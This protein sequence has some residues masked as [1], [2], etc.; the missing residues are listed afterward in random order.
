MFPI[1]ITQLKLLNFFKLHKII[2]W[3][4]LRKF[5][6][7]NTHNYKSIYLVNKKNIENSKELLFNLPLVDYPNNKSL[8]IFHNFNFIKFIRLIRF[9]KNIRI[10][11]KNFFATAEASTR[12]RLHFYDICNEETKKIYRAQSKINYDSYLQAVENKKIGILGTGPSFED[13]KKLYLTNKYHII[14][15]NSA[16]YDDLWRNYDCTLVFADPVFHFG[17]SSEAK[18]FKEEVIKKFSKYK[19]YIFVPTAGFPILHL[20]WG[21]DKDYII[22][23][24]STKGAQSFPLLKQNLTTVRTS[25]VL[26]EFMLPLCANLTKEINLAGFDGREVSEKNFWQYSNKT[27]QNIERHKLNHPS[28]FDDRNIDN[29]YKK[30]INILKKQIMLLEKKDYVISNKTISNIDFLNERIY[31]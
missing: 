16:I 6:L 18:R 29:Y 20:E 8:I 25:N 13:G 27:K 28:F 17:T 21:I 26:T 15:C 11:D 5:Q 3:T 23:I 4:L 9:I 22:G 19:F 14:T 7:E 31:E 12:F 2:T 24:D 1:S 30:H 10:L